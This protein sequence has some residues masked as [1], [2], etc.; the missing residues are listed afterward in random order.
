MTGRFYVANRD[1]LVY[2]EVPAYWYLGG[3]KSLYHLDHPFILS[4]SP[5]PFKLDTVPQAAEIWRYRG[6]AM[7]KDPALWMELKRKY[8]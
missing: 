6:G 8:R 7:V 2:S 1:K 5:P 4:S 3:L